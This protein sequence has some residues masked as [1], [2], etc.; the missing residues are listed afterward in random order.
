MVSFVP[1][2][3]RSMEKFLLRIRICH[4]QVKM[5]LCEFYNTNEAG[6]SATHLLVI[7]EWHY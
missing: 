5:S 3:V 4:F 1:A 7:N 6:S 2:N